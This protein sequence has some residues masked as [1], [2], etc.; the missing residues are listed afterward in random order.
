MEHG[1]LIAGFLFSDT[2]LLEE[3]LALFATEAG[4]IQRRSRCYPFNETE[5][6]QAEMGAAMYRQFFSFSGMIALDEVIRW[7]KLANRVEDRFRIKGK[8]RI[9]IDPGYVDLHKVVLLSAKAGG[10]KMY[11]GHQVWADM[12]LFKKKGG[13]QSFAWTFPDLRAHKYDALL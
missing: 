12:V 3:G 2:T 8:R 6:Y 5:Y 7:K 11:L 13:Y 10:H 9:N 1:K 4:L